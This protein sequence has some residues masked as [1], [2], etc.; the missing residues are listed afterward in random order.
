MGK[1]R[2]AAGTDTGRVVSVRQVVEKGG[3]GAVKNRVDIKDLDERLGKGEKITVFADPETS[4]KTLRRYGLSGPDPEKGWP[5]ELPLTVRAVSG[6]GMVTV[7][8]P[9]GRVTDVGSTCLIMA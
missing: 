3:N 2:T 7:C 6:L 4:P 5:L 1:T 9:R 8:T